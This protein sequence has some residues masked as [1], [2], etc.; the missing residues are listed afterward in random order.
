MKLLV[1]SLLLASSAIHASSSC[2]NL[3]IKIINNSTHNC[4]FKN[5]VIYYGSLPSENIPANISAGQS[6]PIFTASQDSTGIGILLTYMCD[7]EI[8]KFYSWQE[9]CGLGGAGNVGGQP[10]ASTTLNLDYEAQ[11]GSRTSGRSGKITWRIS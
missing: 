2:R 3:D 6:S 9:H 5:K 7:N 1:L 8:V 10:Q 4:T 11:T